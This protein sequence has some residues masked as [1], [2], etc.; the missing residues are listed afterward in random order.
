[1][2]WDWNPMAS[3]YVARGHAGTYSAKEVEDPEWPH[4]KLTFQWRNH[5]DVAA[6]GEFDDL[7]QCK[8]AARNHNRRFR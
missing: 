7:D 5:D 8:Y 2:E 1:M 6:L 3:A 4:W